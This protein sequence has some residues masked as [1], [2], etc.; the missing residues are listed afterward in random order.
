MR[1]VGLYIDV[2]NL[3]FGVQRKHRVRDRLDYKAYIDYCC[4]FGTLGVRNAYGFEKGESS[5]F[6]KVLSDLNINTVY[7]TVRDQYVRLCL[8]VVKDLPQLD[9]V[10]L[11]TTDPVMPILIEEVKRANKQ[12]IVVAAG[13]P[14][15][16][17]EKCN[18]VEIP[19]SMVRK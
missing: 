5:K 6:K 1:Q 4:G 8:D 18:C 11:G 3:Y 12:V 17:R 13:I 9:M 16:W 7:S 19:L 14:E 15:S 2:T 10:L